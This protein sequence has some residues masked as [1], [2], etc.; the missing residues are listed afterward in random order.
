MHLPFLTHL[1]TSYNNHT[2]LP[3]HISLLKPLT[4]AAKSYIHPRYY[5]ALAALPPP[6][7]PTPYRSLLAH[8]TLA[9]NAEVIPHSGQVARYKHI[10]CSH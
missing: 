4:R 7:F 1:P 3:T 2:P 5:S 6:E 10:N 9:T 8:S